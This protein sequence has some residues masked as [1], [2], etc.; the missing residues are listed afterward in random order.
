VTSILSAEP[1][2]QSQERPR[3]PGRW[4]RRLG[5][6]EVLAVFVVAAILLRGI[7]VDLASG[8]Q[9]STFITVAVSVVV[10]GLPFLAVGVILGAAFAAFVRQRLRAGLTARTRPLAVLL[11]LAA[12]ALNPVALVATVV[13]FPDQPRMVIARAVAGVLAAVVTA[14]LWLGV[15]RRPWLL[16]ARAGELDAPQGWS[17]FWERCRSEVVRAGGVLVVGAVA[18]AVLTTWLPARWLDVLG[19]TGLFAVVAMALLAVLLSV[20]A[21]ADAFVAAAV[22]QFPPTAA[23]AFLVVGPMANLRVFTRQVAA[24]GPGFAMIVAPATLV[25]GVGSALFVGWVVF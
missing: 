20:R 24:F 8:E 3:P 16:P 14:G 9:I 22:G 1:T 4:R 10:A 2:P 5:S 17:A 6:I 13:A 19:G 21:E 15:S 18:V 23:L 7:L 25:V 11:A 12:P